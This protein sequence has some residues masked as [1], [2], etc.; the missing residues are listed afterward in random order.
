VCK[1]KGGNRRAKERKQ[2]R[3]AGGEGEGQRRE[4]E[5]QRKKS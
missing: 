2:I 1:Q 3:K 5:R 4:N